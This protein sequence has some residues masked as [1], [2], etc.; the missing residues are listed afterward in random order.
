[1]E[2][3]ADAEHQQDDA[4]FCQLLGQ[5]CVGD[6]ARRVRPDERAGQQIADDRRQADPL[7][8]VSQEERRGEPAGEREN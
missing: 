6:K 4:D 2:L 8:D 7:G 5:R 1:V 3:Q